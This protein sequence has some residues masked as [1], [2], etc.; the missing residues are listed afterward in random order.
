MEPDRVVLHAQ[1]S[2]GI[3]HKM[4]NYELTFILSGDTTAAKQKKSVEKLEEL[5]ESLE[6]RVVDTTLWGKKDLF[7]PVKKNTSGVYYFANI[8]L[9]AEQAAVLNREMEL[10]GEV[11][12][13]LLVVSEKSVVRAGAA[14][15]PKS[16]TS[17]YALTAKEKVTKT[18]KTKK[19]KV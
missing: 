6:G 8:E 19:T 7:Y 16:E 13:H 18:R 1:S 9:P 14:L 17:E 5:V 3:L 11:L 4:R 2:A 15:N 10:D 12:R